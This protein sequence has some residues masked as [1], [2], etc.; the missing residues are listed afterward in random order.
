MW[1]CLVLVLQL[2]RQPENL[3]LNKLPYMVKIYSKEKK[4]IVSEAQNPKKS[5]FFIYS[6]SALLVLVLNGF[7]HWKCT[8][9]YFCIVGWGLILFF[10]YRRLAWYVFSTMFALWCFFQDG[11]RLL[12]SFLLS[13]GFGWSESQAEDSR[14]HSGWYKKIHYLCTT[15][16]VEKTGSSI[17]FLT[18]EL[19]PSNF[20]NLCIFM[21][22]IWSQADSNDSFRVQSNLDYPD[23]DYPVF[24]IIRTFS[25]VPFLPWILISFDLKSF[26]R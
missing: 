26:Q 5:K 4:N 11:R 1:V 9:N 8:S 3:W 15:F 14:K 18:L 12:F 20:Y 21:N 16:P 2:R 7:L 25:L 22:F 23:L 6:G 24:S 19:V 17:A 10:L 13:N